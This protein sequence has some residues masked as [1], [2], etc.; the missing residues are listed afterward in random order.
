MER[1]KSE[2]SASVSF[3]AVLEKAFGVRHVG[4]KTTE[5]YNGI[6][7]L[8][9]EANQLAKNED[10]EGNPFTVK[11]GNKILYRIP[12]AAVDGAVELLRENEERFE[13]TLPFRVT[14][15]EMEQLKRGDGDILQEVIL[16]MER[17]GL[18]LLHS[19]NLPPDQVPDQVF[20]IVEGRINN[21]NTWQ[22][23][24]SSEPPV[25]VKSNFQ[26]FF[27]T[28]LYRRAINYHRDQQRAEHIDPMR[29][30]KTSPLRDFFLQ[31]PVG[32][33]LSGRL[34]AVLSNQSRQ[35]F[36]NHYL[37]GEPVSKEGSEFFI[38]NRL[39]GIV[40]KPIDQWPKPRIS[41]VAERLRREKPEFWKIILSR[42]SHEQRDYVNF[43]Y[44]GEL[45]N[46]QIA[47][48]MGKSVNTVKQ[49]GH[50]FRVKCVKEAIKQGI[51]DKEEVNL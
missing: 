48:K 27:R 45:S 32:S 47:Q 17:L 22:T 31:H 2:I 35:A 20:D 21:P 37:D 30:L 16:R 4:P 6:M 13:N 15:V 42:V 5:L 10:R 36:T 25:P 18:M 29:F 46:E 43:R 12:A 8:I 24:L 51:L 26:R 9:L 33:D 39:E 38:K 1:K 41:V 19:Y 40:N 3:Q 7:S 44:E 34:L 49:I 23:L 28:S 14:A 50:R 11:R